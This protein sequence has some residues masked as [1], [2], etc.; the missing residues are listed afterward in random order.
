MKSIDRNFFKKILSIN[1]GFV[2]VPS[3]ISLSNIRSGKIVCNVLLNELI[4]C[5]ET[6]KISFGLSSIASATTRRDGFEASKWYAKT[7]SMP[8]EGIYR[9]FFC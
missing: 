8:L 7:G 9:I 5:S 1:H 2:V 6:N 4:G 3:L